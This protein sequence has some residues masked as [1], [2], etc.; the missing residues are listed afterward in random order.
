MKNKAL[1]VKNKD[2]EC[3]AAWILST[4]LVGI[5]RRRDVASAPAATHDYDICLLDRV[6]ALEVTR[7]AVP[8]LRSQQAAIA[9]KSWE[10]RTL[11]YNW[12]LQV[13]AAHSGHSGTRITDVHK[14]AEYLL[15]VLERH[16]VERFDPTHQPSGPAEV[17][18]AICRLRE[19]GVAG[20]SS[21]QPP[22][23]MQTR[24]SVG[25]F[26]VGE[27]IDG[28][29]VNEAI[30]RAA[31]EN[32]GKLAKA[33]VDE[34]HLFVWMDRSD[35]AAEASLFLH[36]IPE[37]SPSLPQG[38]DTVWAATWAPRMIYHCYASTLWRVDRGR[39]WQAIHPPDV[40]G[41]GTTI[42]GDDSAV[43]AEDAALESVRSQGY[44]YGRHLRQ[45][46]HLPC[47]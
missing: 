13:D 11:Q 1:E 27:A 32:A 43:R 14:Q 28:A 8:E 24:I 17:I 21:G 26:G 42:T 34:R 2:L 23:G 6:V 10:T 29:A 41:Y 31:S 25:T 44:A 46:L 3:W 37:E 22:P 15:G 9:N 5:P 36:R 45:R 4:V 30:E 47:I 38:V 7:A 39:R 19:L 20:A 40:L 33:D 16:G 35:P 18:D 12:A